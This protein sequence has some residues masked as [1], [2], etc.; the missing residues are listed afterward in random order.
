MKKANHK[1]VLE[2]KI[3]YLKNKQATDLTILKEQ[4]HETI[5]SFTPFNMLKNSIE[6]I[7][8]TPNLKVKLLSQVLNLGTTYLTKVGISAS[9]ENP[10]Q[11]ILG[12]IILFGLNK[13]TRKK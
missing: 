7:L 12:Q 2:A 11:G 3:A 10:V 1:M 4:Y 6:S 8:T 13:I 9:S 5:D